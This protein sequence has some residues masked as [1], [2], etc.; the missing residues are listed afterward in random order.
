MDNKRPTPNRIPAMVAVLLL[1]VLAILLVS[2]WTRPK[3]TVPDPEPDYSSQ[4]VR[5]P[6]GRVLYVVVDFDGVYLGQE[7]LDPRIA[8]D[9][10]NA[11]LK[12]QKIHNLV[13]Y[14]TTH[15]RFGAAADIFTNLDL[16]VV[17]WRQFGLF[18]LKVGD[19]KPLTG[20]LKPM[21]CGYYD[22]ENET[23]P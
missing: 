13:I 11:M 14:G 7:R 20:F 22:S 8:K 1:G 15:A 6:H 23:E 17:R 10:I 16:S 2:H 12:E 5:M 4:I 19:R 18:T 9:V 3:P 21:C